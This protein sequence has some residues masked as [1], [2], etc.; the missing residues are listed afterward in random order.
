[1]DFKKE[2]NL[3][4]IPCPMNVIIT[5]REIE[6]LKSGDI[7]RIIVDFPA[8]KEDVPASLKRW[9]HKILSCVDRG[10]TTEIV[11]QIS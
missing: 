6:N 2:I 10:D 7:V 8:A 5:R 4:G 3:R 1:M 11:V 9:G